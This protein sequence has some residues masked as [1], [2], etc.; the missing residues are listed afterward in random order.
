[1]VGGSAAKLTFASQLKGFP[2]TSTFY[3]KLAD[4]IITPVSSGPNLVKGV[5]STTVMLPFAVFQ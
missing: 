3:I 5:R 1:M 4:L 2:V